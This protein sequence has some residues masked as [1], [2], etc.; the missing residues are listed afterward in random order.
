[1]IAT[2]PSPE[3]ITE[4]FN[5][6]YAKSKEQL[7]ALCIQY[8]TDICGEDTAKRI[9]TMASTC[10]LSFVVEKSLCHAALQGVNPGRTALINIRLMYYIIPCVGDHQSLG[11]YW[12]S[13]QKKTQINIR[14]EKA[15][16][17]AY[18][19]FGLTTQATENR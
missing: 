17:S 12:L 14:R 5:K 7:L 16:N 15:L 19:S 2:K 3:Q 18:H 1:M 4:I 6:F 8:V 9:N 11:D 10:G 13:S